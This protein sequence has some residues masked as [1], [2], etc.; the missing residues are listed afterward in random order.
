MFKGSLVALVTPMTR[1]GT[2]DE[3]AF[4]RGEPEKLIGVLLLFSYRPRR[5]YLCHH[6]EIFPPEKSDV[7]FSTGRGSLAMVL[8][9]KAVS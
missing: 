5:T 6:E 2:L 9:K 7:D 3:K 4:L 8:F 1:E